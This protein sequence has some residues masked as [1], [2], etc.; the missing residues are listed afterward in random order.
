MR[1]IM[2]L[3]LASFIS[4]CAL[5][6]DD[7]DVRNFHSFL[8]EECY[9]LHVANGTLLSKGAELQDLYARFDI[10]QINNSKYMDTHR[11]EFLKAA[12]D[13]ASLMGCVYSNKYS[14]FIY[15]HWGPLEGPGRHLY[16]PKYELLEDELRD[17]VLNYPQAIE[18]MVDVHYYPINVIMKTKIIILR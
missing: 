11:V 15:L 16:L 10:V 13:E 9:Q 2:P 12:G 3:L 7:I 5:F 1:F 17:K 14:E 18:D 4:S 6:S 8:S